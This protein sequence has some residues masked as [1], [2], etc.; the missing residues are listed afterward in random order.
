[1]DRAIPTVQKRGYDPREVAIYA[2]REPESVHRCP[3]FLKYG[4]ERYSIYLLAPTHNT[5]S[6]ISVNAVDSMIR[7]TVTRIR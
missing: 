6:T 4:S 2:R 3:L 5:L 1:M 7:I